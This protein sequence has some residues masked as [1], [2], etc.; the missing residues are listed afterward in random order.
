MHKYSDNWGPVI[1]LVKS[2]MDLVFGGY[3][4]RSLHLLQ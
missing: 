4:S 3:I 2:G 1:F